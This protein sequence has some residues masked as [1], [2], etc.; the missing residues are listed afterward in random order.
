MSFKPSNPFQEWDDS[1]TKIKNELLAIG[2]L[3]MSTPRQQMAYQRLIDL[4][5]ET[6][7]QQ[8]VEQGSLGLAQLAVND[9]GVSEA[10][11][12]E[13]E[14]AA[15]QAGKN[16]AMVQQMASTVNVYVQGTG[17]LDAQAKQEVV[18]AVVEASSYGFGTGWFRTTNRVTL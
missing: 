14:L 13:S 9:I 1:I 8:L 17:G 3:T 7:N 16:A 12:L 2:N 11:L 6:G 15:A 4:G 10:A 5:K 18:D